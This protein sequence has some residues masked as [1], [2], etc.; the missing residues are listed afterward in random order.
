[1]TATNTPEAIMSRTAPY[2]HRRLVVSRHAGQVAVIGLFVL[3]AALLLAAL[4][5]P[6]V[7]GPVGDATP[8]PAPAPAPPPP[9]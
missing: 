7:A 6:L 3:M 4:L 2:T 9:R 8:R 1:L 5:L